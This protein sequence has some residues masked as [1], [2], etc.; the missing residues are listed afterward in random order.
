MS[1][2]G[3]KP[4]FAGYQACEPLNDEIQQR[5]RPGQARRNVASKNGCIRGRFQTDAVNPAT[6]KPGIL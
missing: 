4:A 2:G 5:P 1:F 3:V 6:R